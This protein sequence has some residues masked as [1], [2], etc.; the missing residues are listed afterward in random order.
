MNKTANIRESKV[1][2]NAIPANVLCLSKCHMKE[3]T[4]FLSI[5]ILLPDEFIV[6][7]RSHNV[8]VV[9]MPMFVLRDSHRGKNECECECESQKDHRSNKKAFQ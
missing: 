6:K 8:T 2:I 4:F 9:V 7:A 5:Q 1:G 3:Q